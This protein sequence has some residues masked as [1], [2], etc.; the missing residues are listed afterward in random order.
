MPF[1]PSDAWLQGLGAA[2]VQLAAGEFAAALRGTHTSPVRAL[3]KWLIDALPTPLIDV[4]I[5]LLRRGDKPA[6]AIAL[7]LFSLGVPAMAATAGT[8]TLVAALLLSGLLGLYALWRRTELSRTTAAPLGLVATAAGILGVFFG[9]EASFAIGF[10]AAGLA[11]V[12]R[13]VRKRRRAEPVRLP[14]PQVLLGSP[15]GSASLEIP[16]LSELITPVD[17]FFVTD[18]TFPAPSVVLRQWRLVV[19]GMVEHPLSLTLDELLSLPSREIDAVLMCVH[20]PVGGPF[21]GNARWQGVLLRDLLVRAGA[22]TEADHVR[23]HSVDGFSAGISLSLLEDGFEPMLV[24]AMNSTPLTR[25]HGAPVRVLVP[26]IHGYDANIKWL[27]SVEVMRFSEAIDYAERK[28]WPRRPSRMAPNSRIDVPNHSA[29]L[30]P[31][32]QI[33]AGVAWSPPHGVAKV[34]LRIDGGPW[35]VCALATALG[36]SAWVQWQAPWD[37]TPGRHTLETRTWGREGVQAELA[38]APYPD[39]ARGYHRIA[40]DVQ[41][42]RNPQRRQVGWWLASDAR[43]R[44]LLAWRGITA[45]RRHR[46]HSG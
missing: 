8:A 19:R 11:L 22:A 27:A 29:L 26:G 33:V 30:A 3:G 16:G 45:W 35:Q 20:N 41:S 34:E 24:Y 44:G 46:P 36:P 37:A 32:R 15:P 4:A 38:A 39:G 17:R 23:L 25:A 43:A 6:I 40:V 7:T 21:V 13:R 14:R 9:A 2:F 28:G 31:G 5:A 1:S 12:I 18:V 10:A 42:T